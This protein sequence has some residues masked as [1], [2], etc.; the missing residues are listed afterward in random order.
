MSGAITK[1]EQSAV[2]Y[3]VLTFF[4]LITIANALIRAGSLGESARRLVSP[5]SESFL[6]A[7][8][9]SG[10]VAIAL[11]LFAGG[12]GAW[13]VYGSTELGALPGISWWGI[14]GYS[15]A[16]ALPAIVVGTLGPIVTKASGDRPF[17]TADFGLVR[18]GRLMQL[19]AAAVSCFYMFIYLVAEL[20]SVGG[21]Y[22]YFAG[23]TSDKY[24]NKITISM[25]VFTFVYTGIAGLPA[26]ILTDKIQGAFVLLLVVVITIA[27]ISASENHVSKSEWD[28]ASNSTTAGFRVGVSLIIAVLAAELF[29]QASWQ[30]VYAAKDQKSLIRGFIGGAVLIAPVMMVFGGFGMLSYANDPEGF[31]TF[32]KFP[33]LSFFYLLEPMEKGWKVLVLILVTCLCASSVDSLQN[34]L[35]SVLSRDLTMQRLNVNFSRLLVLGFNIPAIVMAADKYDVL[36]LFLVADLVCAAA[37]P[38]LFLGLIQEDIKIGGKTVFLAP[39]ELGAFLGGISGLVTPIV[40]G[41]P[42][43][44]DSGS[45]VVYPGTASEKHYADYPWSSYWLV[46]N[47]ADQVCALCGEQ[48]LVFFIVTPIIG[49]LCTV[50]FTAMDRLIRG[51]A[52]KK[53]L[54]PS[55]F[56]GWLPEN[57][58]EQEP[59]R[60]GSTVVVEEKQVADQETGAKEEGKPAPEVEMRAAAEVT[61]P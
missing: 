53:P 1:G 12:M 13:I 52:A 37:A 22:G 55:D 58:V 59:V 38:A 27:A 31:D 45:A 54:I 18:Y 51:E 26:S 39:T 16:S 5:V 14:I 47:D 60:E 57:K 11:S 33:Y 6:A 2:L 29:N 35:V 43:L 46:S 34:A 49:A 7:R 21:V 24:T 36:R 17:S 9:S 40:L 3:S 15:I 10:S 20:T 44:Y 30:R 25:G 50:L 19:F 4:L 23:D 32:A 41:A 8:G 61:S 56:W 42:G 28:R 48:V